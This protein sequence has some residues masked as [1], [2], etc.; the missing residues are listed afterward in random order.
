[1]IMPPVSGAPFSLLS[2]VLAVRSSVKDVVDASCAIYNGK[3]N[4]MIEVKGDN[5]L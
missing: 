1:M 5:S 3:V 2:L 4:W